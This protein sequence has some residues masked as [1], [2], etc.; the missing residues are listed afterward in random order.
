MTTVTET[1]KAQLK[2]HQL[3]K[4]QYDNLATVSPTELYAVD[5]ELT[6]GKVLLSDANGDITELN[7]SSADAGK[8][9]V[10]DGTDVSLQYTAVIKEW[11][12]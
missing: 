11:V 12:D 6:G 4:T 9:L 5:L 10:S 3:T 7:T 8:A 1:G 2:I